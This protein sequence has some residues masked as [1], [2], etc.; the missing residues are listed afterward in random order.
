[1]AKTMLLFKNKEIFRGKKSS[2]NENGLNIIN[3]EV[4]GNQRKSLVGCDSTEFHCC[5]SQCKVLFQFCFKYTLVCI[6]SDSSIAHVAEQFSYF[7]EY[8]IAP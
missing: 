2:Q 3:N 5:V 4:I 1:M 8:N 6:S 7:P